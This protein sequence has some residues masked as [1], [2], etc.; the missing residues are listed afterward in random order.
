MANLVFAGTTICTETNGETHCATSLQPESANMV[1]HTY[2][3]TSGREYTVTGT[4]QDDS[5]SETVFIG[6]DGN[7]RTVVKK[8]AFADIITLKD[9]L[10]T[11]L[12]A[13]TQGTL[14]CNI[15]TFTN[16][17]MKAVNFST[18]QKAGDKY[19]SVISMTFSKY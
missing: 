13:G 6:T 3:N 10:S 1:E 7:K 9:T 17:V 5:T 11:M 2:Y 15:G 16:M 4:G 14:T 8:A 19:I 18:I 12:K